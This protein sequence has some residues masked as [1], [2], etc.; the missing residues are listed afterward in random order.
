MVNMRLILFEYCKVRSNLDTCKCSFCHKLSFRKITNSISIHP[1]ED[2]TMKEMIVVML[3]ILKG[4]CSFSAK[5]VLVNQLMNW[6]QAQQYC[7]TYFTDLS[8]LSNKL[9]DQVFRGSVS[10]NSWGWIGLY[11]DSRSPTG[12][13][14]SGGDN[15][16][17]INWGYQMY[18]N[19][20][21]Y[22]F[23]MANQWYPGLRNDL[24]SFFCLNMT[25]VEERKTWEEALQYCRGNNTNLVRLISGTQRLLAASQIQK[26]NISGPVW[27]GLR[28][29]SDRWLWVNSDD[30]VYRDWPQPEGQN[31]QCSAERR[32]G[33]LTTQGLWKNVDCQET[34]NFICF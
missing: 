5:H 31:Y 16:T 29:L 6:Q 20:Y 34:L 11:M 13:M 24:H 3:V 21:P 15:A 1:E 27:I 23:W 30:P 14:W 10:P 28:Y 7:R 4:L 18:Y 9:E 2:A 26:Q 19:Y 12:W 8:P 17:Y 25:V 33:A 22:V 32:C